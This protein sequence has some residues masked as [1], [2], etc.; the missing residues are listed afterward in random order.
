MNKIA[1]IGLCFLII[2]LTACGSSSTDIIISSKSSDTQIQESILTEESRVSEEATEPPIVFAEDIVVNKFIADYN[3]LTNSQFSNISKGNIRTKYF[4]YSYGYRCELL[5]AADTKKICITIN[6]TNDNA[7]V[8]I[9][10]M[11]EVFHD[12]VKTIDLSLTDEEIYKHFDDLIAGE[13]TVSDD[14]FGTMIITFV[15]DKELTSGYS[16]GHI[17]VAAQ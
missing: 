16:R 8:G 2:T 1:Y 17:Q 10:G 7:N 11:R 4:A 14:V 12:V 15:P 6:E 13:T 3:A 9:S 5:N